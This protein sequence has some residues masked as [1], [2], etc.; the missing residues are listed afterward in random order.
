[1]SAAKKDQRDE[2]I[3]KDRRIDDLVAQAERLVTD[4]N[5]TVADMK[6][7]LAVAQVN[8]EVQQKISRR[9]R[10]GQR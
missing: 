3:A 5:V 9:G 8:V 7:I 4:L 1:M 2:L 10:G 6:R